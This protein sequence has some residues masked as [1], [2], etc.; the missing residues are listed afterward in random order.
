MNS[1]GF[2]LVEVLAMLVVLGIL[3]AISVP[4][5]T[6]ILNNSKLSAMKTDGIKMVDTAKVKFTKLKSYEK[7]KTGECIVY[8]LNAVNDTDDISKG[9]NGGVYMTDE[10]FVVIARQNNKYIY[11]VRLVELSDDNKMQGLNLVDSNRLYEKKSDF[12][13]KITDN[14][15]LKGDIAEETESLKTK[16]SSKCPSG[17][18]GYYPGHSFN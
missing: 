14:Y 11:Y 12:I 16:L 1:K 7:P 15:E 6:G 5:V 10:S 18:A 9:P 17:I 3:M 2:T 8:G 13:G 4:N